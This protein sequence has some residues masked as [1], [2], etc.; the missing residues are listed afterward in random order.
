[1][2]RHGTYQYSDTFYVH[3]GVDGPLYAQV[4]VSACPLKWSGGRGLKLTD[5]GVE[6][7]T[8]DD[9]FYVNEHCRYFALRGNRLVPVTQW[10]SLCDTM[11]GG[12]RIAY[13]V[14]FG[15]CSVLVPMRVRFDLPQGGLE[16]DPERSA[17]WGGLAKMK[18]REVEAWVDTA[19][20][21]FLHRAVTGEAGDSIS[22][23]L[24]SEIDVL[25][26][27]GKC[28][29][30]GDPDDIRVDVKR[31]EVVVDGKHG[32]VDERDFRALGF[33]EREDFPEDD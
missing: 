13:P 28:A 6:A 10:C 24:D 11:V 18:V 8:V 1:V 27:Y 31:V 23:T 5:G 21:V 12:D 20:R 9:E 7:P 16:V 3:K 22:V 33:Y 26:A 17:A 25:Q 14:S 29:T 30:A 2:D 19:A 15:W 32:F 4:V